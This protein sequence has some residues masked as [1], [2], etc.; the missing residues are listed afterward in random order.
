MQTILLTKN[1][2][3][4]ASEFVN[5]VSFNFHNFFHRVDII[6][7]HSIQNTCEQISTFYSPFAAILLRRGRA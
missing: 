4:G 1:L 3:H 2:E 5:S 6:L 7:P